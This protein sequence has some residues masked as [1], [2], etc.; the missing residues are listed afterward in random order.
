MNHR[1][2]VHCISNTFL[3]DILNLHFYQCCE[4]R[5]NCECSQ[6]QQNCTIYVGVTQQRT[7]EADSA[8]IL[9]IV[10]VSQ[11]C[12]IYAVRIEGFMYKLHDSG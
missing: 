10:G 1:A 3:S 7:E 5:S 12:I 2:H 8:E 4:M 9:S 6:C 11:K